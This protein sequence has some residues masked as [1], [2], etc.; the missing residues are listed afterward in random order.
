VRDFVREPYGAGWHLDRARYDHD[1]RTAAAE[2]G[3]LVDAAARVETVEPEEG[4]WRVRL[5]GGRGRDEA[6]R[7]DR[8]AVQRAGE[9]SEDGAPS[10]RRRPPRD[11][12]HD[13]HAEGGDGNIRRG[14]PGHDEP[15][16]LEVRAAW[17]IDATGRAAAVA[18]RLGA[19]RRRDDRLVAFVARCRRPPGAPADRDDRTWVEAVDGGWWYSARV[20]ADER[21]FAFHT[22]AAPAERRAL[23]DA[24]G[25]AERLR[26]APRLGALFA[27]HGYRPAGRPRGVDASSGR[28][29][30]AAG[31]GW[32]AVGDAA[33]SFDPLSSQGL[34]NAHYT[35]LRGAEAVHRALAGDAAAVAAYAARLD[36]IY[37]AY[38]A[39]R[40]AAY[41]AER[42]WPAAPFWSTRAA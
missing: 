39:H 5:G 8:R 40:A 18:R 9:R 12:R 14:R 35:G 27:A 2:A 32:L 15:G 16:E 25:F 28:L 19:R 10:G 22:E 34:L 7:A 23:L 33:A 29:G 4:G 11:V 38:L 20:P 1:L 3:A 37:R 31:R 42:R 26:R 13:G 21:V 17:L 30:A 36:E 24:A 41:A 6:E